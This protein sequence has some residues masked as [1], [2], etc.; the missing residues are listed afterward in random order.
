M[1]VNKWWCLLGIIFLKMLSRAK[2]DLIT[3]YRLEL[4][5]TA[6]NLEGAATMWTPFQPSWCSLLLTNIH[7]NYIFTV[8]KS[9]DALENE[10]TH[11]QHSKETILLKNINTFYIKI[12]DQ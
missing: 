6:P 12:T 11:L 1:K 3:P 7:I 5:T 4:Q 2:L 8:Y 10:N 9:F